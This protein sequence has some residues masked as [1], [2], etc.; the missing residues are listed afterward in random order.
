MATSTVRV[1]ADLHRRIATL[2]EETHTTMNQVVERA[3]TELEDREF[4]LRCHAALDK[5]NDEE[6]SD[7]LGERALLSNTLMD[8]LE[9]T[10]DPTR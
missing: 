5:T 10:G 9:E 2:A 1:D 6:W 4:W 3:I 7:Y 8:D